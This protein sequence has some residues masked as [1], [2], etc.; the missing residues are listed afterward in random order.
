M[1]LLKQ[2]SF[3]LRLNTLPHLDVI[4]LTASCICT[5]LQKKDLKG[6]SMHLIES[7]KITCLHTNLWRLDNN[8]SDRTFCLLV[9]WS[10]SCDFRFYSKVCLFSPLKMPEYEDSS[11]HLH[12]GRSAPLSKPPFIR[13]LHC[14]ESFCSFTISSRQ[15]DSPL[16]STEV[17]S[18]T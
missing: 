5:D 9:E 7:N 2:K 18:H 15:D 17:M 14:S 16:M 11:S 10:R 4:L 12:S 6:C 1:V 13:V 3:S 8:C